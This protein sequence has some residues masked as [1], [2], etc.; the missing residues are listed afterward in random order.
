[1]K[2][3]KLNL[4]RVGEGK[5]GGREEVHLLTFGGEPSPQITIPPPPS[6]PLQP[7]LAG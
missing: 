7:R 6:L 5:G 3:K 4:L 2:R 1:M